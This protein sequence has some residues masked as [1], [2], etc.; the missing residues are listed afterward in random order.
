MRFKKISIQQ[1]DL[2]VQVLDITQIV[3][4]FCD[5]KLISVVIIVVRAIIN[6]LERGI[7]ENGIS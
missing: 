3:N 6:K 7:D 2:I 5:V 1:R 4:V